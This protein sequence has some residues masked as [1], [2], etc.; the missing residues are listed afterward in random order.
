MENMKYKK[1]LNDLHDV[2]QHN[3]DDTAVR[4][5]I[6]IL[7]YVIEDLVNY[8]DILEREIKNGNFNAGKS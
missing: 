3:I 1:F 7:A 4:D 5:S 2:F 6:Y 8:I